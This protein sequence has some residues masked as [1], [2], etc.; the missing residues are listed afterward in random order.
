LT[1]LEKIQLHARFWDGEGPSLILIPASRMPQYDT[2]R[3][4][5]LFEH[6][7]MMWQSEMCRAR[8]VVDWPTDGIPTVRPNL[9]VVFVPGIAGQAYTVWNDGMP[10]PG[11]PLSR[12]TIRGLRG[13]AV[14]ETKM[15][16]LALEFY[17]VHQASGDRDIA[18][19]HPDTQGIFSLAHLLNGNST[20]LEVLDD[21]PWIHELLGIILEMN[22]RVVRVLKSCLGEQNDSMVHGHGTPQGVYFPNAGVRISEDA[23]TLVSPKVLDNFVLP[24]LERAISPFNQGFVHYCGRHPYLFEQLC[25]M[26][27]VCAI[28]LGNPEMYDTRW[29]F[30]RCGETGTVLFSP[31]AALESESWIAYVHRVANLVRETGARLIL[32]PTVYPESRDDCARMVDL[33]HDLTS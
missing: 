20:L 6:P 25:L 12:D 32:R 2:K 4:A 11:K 9:G 27:R 1:T 18:A 5:D 7:R 8:P 28:D 33:W 17:A 23:A 26:G 19:Y 14:S 24:Y 31:V 30:E 22:C 10:W 3:Y 16:R 13:V 15:M 21:P 29:L